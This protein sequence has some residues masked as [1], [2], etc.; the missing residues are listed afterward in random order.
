MPLLQ[1]IIPNQVIELCVT[2][3]KYLLLMTDYT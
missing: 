3:K 1:M 2:S